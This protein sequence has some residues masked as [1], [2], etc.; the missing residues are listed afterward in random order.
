MKTDEKAAM[1][2]HHI[3]SLVEDPDAVARRREQ[4]VRAGKS[5]EDA[6]A[7]LLHTPRAAAENWS[8]LLESAVANAENNHELDGD[9]LKILAVHADEGPTLKRFRPRAQGRAS[10]IRKRT[11][12][13]SIALGPKEQ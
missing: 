13:L 4:I 5:V 3:V 8:K 12:H 7:I 9:D 6:R 1:T 10:A 2:P 11:A